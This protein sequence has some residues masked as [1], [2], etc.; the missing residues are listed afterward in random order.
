MATPML[1][2]RAPLV[3]NGQCAVSDAERYGDASVHRM[4]HSRER[5]NGPCLA[6]VRCQTPL[7]RCVGFSTGVPSGRRRLASGGSRELPRAV[8]SAAD[9]GRAFVADV[10]AVLEQDSLRELVRPR[11]FDEGDD[12]AAEATA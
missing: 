5:T 3:P 4:H 8:G 1:V 6:P 11:V 2:M 12:R 7:R 10:A 9:V